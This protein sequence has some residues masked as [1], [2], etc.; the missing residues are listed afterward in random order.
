[1]T[2][3][4]KKVI[5]VKGVMTPKRA[6][7]EAINYLSRAIAIYGGAYIKQSPDC[8]VVTPEGGK[9]KVFRFAWK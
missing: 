8:F 3:E 7:E 6:F 9:P 4:N 1:M 5:E 2:N